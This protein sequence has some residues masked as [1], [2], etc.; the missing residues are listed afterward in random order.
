[1]VWYHTSIVPYHTFSYELYSDTLS[2]TD[3]LLRITLDVLTVN[4]LEYNTFRTHMIL[5]YKLR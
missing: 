3:S 1:M 5:L 4:F 2:L